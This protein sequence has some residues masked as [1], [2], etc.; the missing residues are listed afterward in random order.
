MM[1]KKGRSKNI[2]SKNKE[3]I[4]SVCLVIL[5]L[6]GGY[7]LFFYENDLLVEGDVVAIV[8]GEKITRESVDSL[9]HSYSMYGVEFS[10]AEALDNLISITLLYQKAEEEG[11]YVD[12]EELESIIKPQLAMQG[13]DLDDFKA[14]LMMQGISYEEYKED[15]AREIALNNY[16]E[17]LVSG[18]P[19][20]TD[21]EIEEYYDFAKSQAQD[22]ENFPDFN[23]S[24]KEEIRIFLEQDKQMMFQQQLIE[25][26]IQELKDN[27]E[28]EYLQEL[29][30]R[31]EET[32]GILGGFA[33]E[34][35]EE[36]IQVGE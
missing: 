8:N 35:L 15:V 32:G 5:L 27:A 21:E 11:F 29:D 19:D 12:D 26:L 3:I 13:M 4:V 6:F 24:V 14:Q 36:G 18:I 2:F 34:G 31:V 7:F 10:D 25:P 20:V 33:I 16:M 17:S 30:T 9:K 23:E 22:L 1:V 28:I